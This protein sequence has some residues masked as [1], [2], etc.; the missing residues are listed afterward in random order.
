[1]P[2][3]STVILLM[4]LLLLSG[5]DSGPDVIT[6]RTTVPT[7]PIGAVADLPRAATDDEQECQ[8]YQQALLIRGLVCESQAGRLDNAALA[9]WMIQLRLSGLGCQGR[10][11]TAAGRLNAARCTTLVANAPCGQAFFSDCEAMLLWQ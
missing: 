11:A 9:S 5:C 2:K 3:S 8:S 6:L 7:P 10:A 4:L 1:M